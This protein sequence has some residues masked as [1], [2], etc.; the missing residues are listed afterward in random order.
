MAFFTQLSG[1]PCTAF[2][3]N[4]PYKYQ[5]QIRESTMAFVNRV[6]KVSPYL[7]DDISWYHMPK[8]N[9]VTCNLSPFINL[10][11][12]PAPLR[13]TILSLS[14][15]TRRSGWLSAFVGGGIPISVSRR[16][17]VKS[18]ARWFWRILQWEDSTPWHSSCATILLPSAS[19]V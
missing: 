18:T 2:R 5:T 11:K 17:L 16:P 15:G 10:I 19:C 3:V 7:K 14:L 6:D 13:T 9:Y 1:N 8:T 4:M 12:Y